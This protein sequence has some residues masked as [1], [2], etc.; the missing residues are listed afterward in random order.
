MRGVCG[1]ATSV[2]INEWVKLSFPKAKSQN[3][4]KKHP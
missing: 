2:V 3:F 1:E 4:L